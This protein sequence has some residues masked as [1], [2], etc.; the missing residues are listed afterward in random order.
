LESK[1]NGTSSYEKYSKNASVQRGFM[2]AGT[3]LSV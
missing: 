2:K 3:N 1:N